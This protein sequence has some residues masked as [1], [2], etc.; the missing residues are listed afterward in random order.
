MATNL[1]PDP[2]DY[3]D[4]HCRHDNWKYRS[5][6]IDSRLPTRP[7]AVVCRYSERFARH[8]WFYHRRY[9][10]YYRWFYRDNKPCYRRFNDGSTRGS[11]PDNL[12]IRV[13]SIR[14]F[15]QMGV[16]AVSYTHLRA[17]ETDSYL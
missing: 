7:R 10:G 12:R 1:K 16:R 14:L 17:H 13:A 5:R 15:G 3:R 9:I 11:V 8:T 2:S 4:R 6:G